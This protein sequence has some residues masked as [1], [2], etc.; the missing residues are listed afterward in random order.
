MSS[1]SDANS[2]PPHMEIE[3]FFNLS[4]EEMA[5]YLRQ[6][7]QADGGFLITEVSGLDRFSAS[8]RMELSQKL[9]AATQ[10]V[11]QRDIDAPVDAD[12]LAARLE[13]VKADDNPWVLKSLTP[14]P[15]RDST[16]TPPPISLRE[17]EVNCYNDLVAEHGRPLFPLDILDDIT[18]DPKKYTLL[19]RPWMD[20]PDSTSPD[21]WRVFSK[22][23]VR[24]Q[25]FRDWQR[26]NREIPKHERFSAFFAMKKRDMISI[27][28]AK[29]VAD[30]CYEKSIRNWWESEQDYREQ[31][32]ESIKLANSNEGFSGYIKLSRYTLHQ[33]G[34]N[35]HV[36][37]LE[38]IEEQD[39]WTTWMEYIAYEC[40]RLDSDTIY[41]KYLEARCAKAWVDLEQTGVL[42][43]S[44]TKQSLTS[45]R[46]IVKRDAEEARAE[47]RVLHARGD[48]MPCRGLP[49]PLLSK[50]LITSDNLQDA[51]EALSRIRDRN[52]HID[53]FVKIAKR[54]IDAE[55]DL[56]RGIALVESII[57]ELSII[58]QEQ[59]RSPSE[60]PPL[61]RRTRTPKNRVPSIGKTQVISSAADSTLKR[62]RSSS[63][64]LPI[65]PGTYNNSKRTC[66]S[67]DYS[68]ESKPME[69]QGRLTSSEAKASIAVDDRLKTH[70][71]RFF[72]PFRVRWY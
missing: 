63:S 69:A 48:A 45:A 72:D 38:N 57:A 14:E 66:M 51:E 2:A 42:R 13:T 71:N 62:K 54:H 47:N 60:R 53:K 41:T 4:T 31:Q 56:R 36:E 29:T 30:S 44:D 9:R 68:E 65:D 35:Q 67:H 23:Q 11:C 46:A 18:I 59:A 24:W 15:C 61:I 33:H 5:N 43:K 58:E 49:Y 70:K 20:D 27:G 8:K 55:K 6:T 7:K 1:H 39:P 50:P 25:D 22:Q 16:P 26:N 40:R 21:D 64:S 17:H 19:L 52:R 37:F 3:S 10:R 28:G 12:K 32:L 34:V